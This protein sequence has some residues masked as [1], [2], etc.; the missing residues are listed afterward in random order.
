LNRIVPGPPPW[1]ALIVHRSSICSLLNDAFG[2]DASDCKSFEDSFVEIPGGYQFYSPLASISALRSYVEKL[3]CAGSSDSDDCK[4]KV[5]PLESADYVDLKY[6]AISQTLVAN[7]FWSRPEKPW[8]E[9]IKSIKG[10]NNIEVGV[11]GNE[12]PMVEES[13]TLAGVLHVVAKDDKLG[14]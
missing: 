7:T 6:D 11:L 9:S 13:L 8:Q 1:A 4:S 10:H 12:K 2:L 5:G 3:L 14:T